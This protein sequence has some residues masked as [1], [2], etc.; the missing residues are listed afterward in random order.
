MHCV[1]KHDK[2][3]WNYGFKCEPKIFYSS[4]WVCL[5][6]QK[7]GLQ[8]RNK[9]KT[10]KGMRGRGAGVCNPFCL[11]VSAVRLSSA[12]KVSQRHKINNLI[13]LIASSEFCR[14]LS[15]CKSPCHPVE[16]PPPPFF[17]SFHWLCL[18]RCLIVTFWTSGGGGGGNSFRLSLLAVYDVSPWGKKNPVKRKLFHMSDGHSLS[19]I[20][21]SFNISICWRRVLFICKHFVTADIDDDDVAPPFR[22]V[23]VFC[24]PLCFFVVVVVVKCPFIFN[25]LKRQQCTQKPTQWRNE[26]DK[27]HTEYDGENG[28]SH[29]KCNTH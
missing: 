21:D 12:D 6:I 19:H 3:N 25:I 7:H 24:Q 5:Y 16:P 8:K 4:I 28:L 23:F 1:C 20:H 27:T 13:N 11:F 9:I 17:K 14:Q 2:L 26:S 15:S 18:P 10:N 22:F 29:C